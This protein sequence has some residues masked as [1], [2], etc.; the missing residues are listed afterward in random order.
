MT[1]EQFQWVLLAFQWNYSLFKIVFREIGKLLNEECGRVSHLPPQAWLSHQ[2]VGGEAETKSVNTCW[3]SDKYWQVQGTRE[4]KKSQTVW[5]LIHSL[6]P[7]EKCDPKTI[8]R[9]TISTTRELNSPPRGRADGA[10]NQQSSL[11]Y[12]PIWRLVLENSVETQGLGIKH[13]FS[14]H[15]ENSSLN[16][17]FTLK[18]KLGLLR[19]I[20]INFTFKK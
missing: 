5:H 20:L 12:C 6:C 17:H 4:E 8:R 15:S 2:I 7:A 3:A 19:F 16:V 18:K 9:Q 11:H 13:P 10:S 14:S 1:R